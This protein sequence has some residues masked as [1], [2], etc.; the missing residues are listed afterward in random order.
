MDRGQYVILC[1]EVDLSKPLSSKFKLNGQIWKI[2]YEGSRMMC[3]KCV[4]LGHKQ[5]NCG[6]FKPSA[7]KTSKDNQ[8]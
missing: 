7:V 3:F 4:H 6:V 5:D 2:Q 8:N 1:I